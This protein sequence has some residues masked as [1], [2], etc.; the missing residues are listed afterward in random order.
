MTE[1]LPLMGSLNR[2]YIKSNECLTEIHINP[3]NNLIYGLTYHNHKQAYENTKVA[4]FWF[5]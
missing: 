4:S 2:C 5:C 1:F 3:L